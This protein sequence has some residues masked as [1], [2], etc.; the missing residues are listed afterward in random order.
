[1]SPSNGGEKRLSFGNT[2]SS[3]PPVSSHLHSS[4]LA[5]GLN[6]L[7]VR[8]DV[9]ST[10]DAQGLSTNAVQVGILRGK[11]NSLQTDLQKLRAE[12]KELH[13]KLAA[14]SIKLNEHKIQNSSLLSKQNTLLSKLSEAEHSEK[15][16]EEALINERKAHA[17]TRDALARAKLVQRDLE[18]SLKD[19]RGRN[20]AQVS[21]RPSLGAL[22][23]GARLSDRSQF[24]PTSEHNDIIDRFRRN[25]DALVEQVKSSFERMSAS[26]EEDETSQ[27]ITRS[28]VLSAATDL[29][30]KLCHTDNVLETL[31]I[32]MEQ[33]SREFEDDTGRMLLSLMN[34]NKELW[35]TISKQRTELDSM[36][37][38]LSSRGNKGDY[39]HKDKLAYLQKQNKV[40]EDRLSKA[41]AAIEQQLAAE[42]SHADGM[43][44]LID[45]N[46][47]LTRD[48]QDLVDE[49]ET[50][51][52]QLMAKEGEADDAVMQSKALQ[53]QVGDLNQS[54]THLQNQLNSLTERLRSVEE[55]H[56]AEL[57]SA[58]R[59]AQTERDDAVSAA[60]RLRGDLEESLQRLAA[61]EKEL[62][63]RTSNFSTR[64]AEME[65]QYGSR[66]RALQEELHNNRIVFEREIEELRQELS[67]R[68][69]EL[70][71]V[72]KHLERERNLH[73][74]IDTNTRSL[75]EQRHQLERELNHAKAHQIKSEE[76]IKKLQEELEHYRTTA[77]G[78]DAKNA[79]LLAEQTQL[80]QQASKL[81]EE[82]EEERR[83]SDAKCSNLERDYKE[84][85][86]GRSVL[87]EEVTRLRG[88]AD[89]DGALRALKDRM[90]REKEQ[91]MQE[92]VRLHQQYQE[93]QQ[94]NVELQS[95]LTHLK[96]RATNLGP[97]QQ[98]LEELQRRLQELPQLR[99]QAEDARRDYQ[100][101]KE[102]MASL[103]QERDEMSQRL[104]FFLEESR[105]A[106]KKD[107]DL[108]RLFK[109]AS[110]QVKRLDQQI[111]EVTHRRGDSSSRGGV[112]GLNGGVNESTASR[113]AAAEAS[114]QA[115]H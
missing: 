23:D 31:Q 29:E 41:H 39:V 103:K 13:D 48:N 32:T 93:V 106:T 43:R 64:K 78:S 72:N 87:V 114:K 71:D 79:A 50:L 104:E 25:H 28:A 40:M 36:R 109:E 37:S 110:N 62:D 55:Q 80:I 108:D 60:S 5:S 96:S 67:M 61:L 111:D 9:G 17:S 45:D 88:K 21:R 112:S 15:D 53:R 49:I 100:R 24:I 47:R 3:P 115:W 69:E 8:E 33:F 75:E 74:S 56:N 22:D 86:K 11:V 42:R 34:E 51:R 105:L 57:R 70:Q 81:E 101:L 2:P 10:L 19:L 113:R 35:Q 26:Q 59:Q 52:Q 12:H 89:E 102:E 90:E 82:L 98:Q 7:M 38:D 44:Q 58:L 18:T 95:Q 94:R 92:N 20:S 46:D 14:N 99:Q 68:N 77:H 84:A 85:V 4:S 54:N 66:V 97:L 73:D 30:T 83:R 27:F 6:S 1:M 76:R 91:L 107:T 63:S 16:L 65:S